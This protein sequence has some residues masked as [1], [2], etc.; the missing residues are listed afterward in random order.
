MTG[1]TYSTIV[2]NIYDT[3]K[4]G[5]V[6]ISFSFSNKFSIVIYGINILNILFFIF[7]IIKYS[8]KISII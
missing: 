6:F 4:Y 2:P 8:V 7:L 1:L 5:D 3:F